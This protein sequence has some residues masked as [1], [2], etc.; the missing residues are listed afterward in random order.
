MTHLKKKYYLITKTDPFN[1]VSKSMNLHNQYCHAE[2]RCPQNRWAYKTWVCLYFCNALVI[3]A[4][5]EL[6]TQALLLKET[7]WKRQMMNVRVFF[8]G[9]EHHFRQ[10]KKVMKDGSRKCF[11]K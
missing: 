1:F 10:A 3:V 6:L 9:N 8:P 7:F 11:L 2:S 4:N 5:N